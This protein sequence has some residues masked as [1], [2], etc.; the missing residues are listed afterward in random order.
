VAILSAVTFIIGYF[1]RLPLPGTQGIFTLADLGIF[2]SAFAFGPF[3]AAIAGGIGTALIDLIGGTAQYAL[4]SFFV[5]GLEGLLAGI[6]ASAG[7]TRKWEPLF[8]IAAGAVGVIVMVGGYFLAETVFFGGPATALTE[9]LFNVG[10]AVIGAV[11]G[12]LLAL[13]VKK[14]YPPISTLRW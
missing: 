12:A 13:A 3:T 11:G 4:I 7:F 8:W 6:I 1:V 2:F 14:A 9:V 5:H 10:Q